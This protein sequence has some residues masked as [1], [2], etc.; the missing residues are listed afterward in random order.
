MFANKPKL[1]KELSAKTKNFSALPMK[2]N[3]K[4]PKVKKPKMP[5]IKRT[6]WVDSVK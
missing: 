4:K 5:S 6:K 1:A 2:L 3:P